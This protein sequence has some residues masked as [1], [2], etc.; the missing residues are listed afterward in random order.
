M[1]DKNYRDLE[2]SMRATWLTEHKV[3]TRLIEKNF[4]S[5]MIAS[6]L[7]V[8]LDLVERI[9]KELKERVPCTICRNLCCPLADGM[10][11]VPPVEICTDCDS[12]FGTVPSI[13]IA[14]TI[15]ALEEGEK[16]SGRERKGE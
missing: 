3:I 7:D 15:K 12:K 9:R 13:R 5:E 10:D 16:G 11:N 4:N 1:E 14:E 2:L 6:E 8:D